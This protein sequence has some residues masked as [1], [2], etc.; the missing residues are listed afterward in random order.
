M[1]SPF[2]FL[3]LSVFIHA[4][5]CNALRMEGG[6]V[7]P[8]FPVPGELGVGEGAISVPTLDDCQGR[9]DAQPW[10]M[11][12]DCWPGEMAYLL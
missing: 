1:N 7:P 5:V 4:C 12:Q 11:V 9:Q 8:H 3:F 10:E 2:H 6:C